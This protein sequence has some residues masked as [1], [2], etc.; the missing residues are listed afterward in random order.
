MTEI[1][2]LLDGELSESE[3]PREGHRFLARGIGSGVGAQLASWSVY[4]LPPGQSGA[5]YHF[6]LSREEWVLVVTGEVTLRSP[7]GERVLRPGDVACF[8]PG[9]DGAHALRNEGAGPARY[10]MASTK[11]ASKSIVYPDAGRVAVVGPGFQ[12]MLDIG[13][14]PEPGESKA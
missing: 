2:N 7:A 13:E 14:G 12:R 10:A 11:S 5:D 1:F 4:E 6:E 3:H 9:L 8:T